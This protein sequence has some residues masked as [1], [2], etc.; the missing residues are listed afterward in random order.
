MNR[1]YPPDNHKSSQT[2]YSLLLILA[3]FIWGTAFVAQSSAGSAVGSY[4]Y[5][6]V[7]SLVGA[8]VLTP[9]IAF[10]DRKGRTVRKPVTRE[11]KK[12][13]VKGGVCVGVVLFF[14]S[15]TQQL[16]I[17]LGTP[18]GK[19]G[20]LTACY[21]TLVPVLG[22]VIKKKTH[23]YV[24]LAILL[25][26]I[27]LYFL[28]LPKGAVQS[29]LLRLSASDSFV[30][31]CALAYAVHIL[32]VDH[33]SPRVDPI[34]LSRIQ[35]LT[36]AVL[37]AIPMVLLDMGLITQGNSALSETLRHLAGTG[38]TG[39]LKAW[40]SSL[41]I[42]GVWFSML[43]TGLFSSGVA[44]TLQVV[45]Q[46]KVEPAKASVYMSLES[47]FSVLSGWLILGDRLSFR[48]LFGCGMIFIAVLLAQ[49]IGIGKHTA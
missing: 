23:W 24:W 32:T 2:A 18:A 22:I 9:V 13:L 8:L 49:G 48:E 10:F 28:C 20:F 33:F 35:F 7:R 46:A 11:E 1:Y 25:A 6:C 44:F 37:S 31:L 41:Q 34:R 27:G 15:N 14:A 17:A 39:S 43:Y 47:V 38:G 40:I 30:L 21:M 29:G 45:A 36:C 5:N 16:G 19:A 3:A 26:V 4:T 12:L 42:P